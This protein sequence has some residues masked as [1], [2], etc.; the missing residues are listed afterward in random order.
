MRP[1]LIDGLLREGET[2]NV[3]A[4]PK[5]GKSFLIL[6]LAVAVARGEPWLGMSTTQG[7]VLLIDGELH[8]ETLSSR[9][10]QA[11]KACGASDADMALVEVLDAR[12]E[13]LTIEGIADALEGVGGGYR[14]IILDALYRFLPEGVEEN[15]NE[16][17]TRVYNTIDAIARRTNAAM[18][19][20]HHTSKGNQENKSVT[21]VGSGAGS[22]SRAADTH[23]TVRPYEKNN[24][25]LV[26]VDAVVRSFPPMASFAIESTNP[27]W[28]RVGDVDISQL[29]KNAKRRKPPKP[30]PEPV[31]TWTPAEFAAEVVGSEPSIKAD[32]IARAQSQG[33]S[34]ATA[35]SL[36]E[37]AEVSD[38]VFRTEDG[39]RGK[40]RFST[41]PPPTETPPPPPEVSDAGGVC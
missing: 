33:L 19:V 8:L 16:G 38:L 26:V 4:A 12:G 1:V 31:R 5:I 24:D 30:T 22:Q 2:M 21:D 25:A 27:G 18:V 10:K 13:R 41:T 37:R 29:L 17:I 3:V 7:R 11:Q 9:L 39:P 6:S 20:V 32:V 36:L 14:M 34:K 23:L 28:R 35:E 15:S 40:H